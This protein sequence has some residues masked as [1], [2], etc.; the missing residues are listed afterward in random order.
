MS[1]S[2]CT[3]CMT[4][5]PTGSGGLGRH[6]LYLALDTSMLWEQYCIIRISV[7]YRGEQCRWCG[8]SSSHASSSV[9]YESTSLC[10]TR[11]PRYCLCTVTS[12]SWRIVA[13]RHELMAMRPGWVALA[14]PDQ[15][16]LRRVSP[17][18]PPAQTEQ[19]RAQAG[20][21]ALLQHVRIT[22]QRYGPCAWP[23]RIWPTTVNAGWWSAMSPLA[24][25]P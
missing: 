7:I 12:C 10:W 6:T 17:R 14:H 16:M 4:L 15:G 23:W 21:C 8:R 3:T 24:W 2:T 9:A 11:P 5:T 18:P 25:R 20:P 13:L 22:D 1:A 19:L